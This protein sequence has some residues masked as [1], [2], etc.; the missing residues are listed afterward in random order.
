MPATIAGSERRSGEAG[1]SLPREAWTIDIESSTVTHCGPVACMSCS[2]RP[3]QGR[4]S[5]SLAVSRQVRLSLVTMFTDRSSPRIAAKQAS[6]SGI[7]TARLPPSAMKA[8]EWPSSIAAIDSTALWPCLR[9]GAKPNAFSM[10]ESSASLGIS[11]MPTV[12]SP[13]TLLWPRN[14][15][16]PA[17]GLPMLPRIRS[18]LAICWTFS[19]PWRCWVMPM[20]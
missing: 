19:V 12:R 1:L 17:P 13:C 6:G 3:R 20:P 5:V 15:Q 8:R 2:V 16:M 14:G 7:A 11:V 9:G 10:P 18:R 4:I